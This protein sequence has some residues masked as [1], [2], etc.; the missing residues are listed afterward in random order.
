MVTHGNKKTERNPYAKGAQSVAFRPKATELI[1]SGRSSDFPGFQ[2]LPIQKKQNSGYNVENMFPTVGGA[3]ITA[4]GIVPD[5][6]RIPFSSLCEP[7]TR[8]I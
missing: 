6:H 3:G 2:L 4:T 5:L 8:Q 1:A 7:I